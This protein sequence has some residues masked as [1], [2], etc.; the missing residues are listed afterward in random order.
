MVHFFFSLKIEWEWRCGAFFSEQKLGELRT[1]ESIPYENRSIF[2]NIIWL[3]ALYHFYYVCYNI[4]QFDDDDDGDYNNKMGKYYT[5]SIQLM[6]VTGN[7]KYHQK[8]L[9]RCCNLCYDFQHP[10]VKSYIYSLYLCLSISIDSQ[11]FKL[12]VMR[13]RE[14]ECNRVKNKQ[15]NNSFDARQTENRFEIV[16]RIEC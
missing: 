14:K 4:I 12:S 2:K 10:F 6:M 13:V 9:C 15:T 8:S 5:K 3:N 1:H 7:G 11:Y 16:I